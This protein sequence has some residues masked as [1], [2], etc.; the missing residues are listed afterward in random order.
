MA[1]DRELRELHNASPESRARPTVIHAFYGDMSHLVYSS[2]TSM[3]CAKIIIRARWPRSIGAT[4]FAVQNAPF[5]LRFGLLE[6]YGSSTL[7]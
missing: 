4:L 7:L 2:N 6:D 5:G 3:I 1:R